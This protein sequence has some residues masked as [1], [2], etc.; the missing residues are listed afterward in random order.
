MEWEKA[1]ENNL[2]GYEVRANTA[3]K[4]RESG[5]QWNDLCFSSVYDSFTT[6]M[7]WAANG[8]NE[9]DL[10]GLVDS[11]IDLIKSHTGQVLPVLNMLA[12]IETL[13][14]IWRTQD[15]DICYEF[16][17][18]L[19]TQTLPASSNDAVPKDQAYASSLIVHVNTRLKQLNSAQ[20]ILADPAHG[21]G[22]TIAIMTSADTPMVGPV[23]CVIM[24]DKNHE[25]PLYLFKVR[26]AAKVEID[27]ACG[28]APSPAHFGESPWLGKVNDELLPKK[29]G[30]NATG[31]VILMGDFNVSAFNSDHKKAKEFFEPWQ[32]PLPEHIGHGT[33]FTRNNTFNEP[34]DKIL[35]RCGE[36]ICVELEG[37]LGRGPDCHAYSDHSY[38]T[39]TIKI[40]NTKQCERCDGSA[41]DGSGPQPQR[42][43]MDE[44]GQGQPSRL[45]RRNTRGPG[46]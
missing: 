9:Q 35:I 39:R 30:Q 42:E 8:S 25:R 41:A 22:E 23:K 15:L 31:P 32:P 2:Y 7:A 17:E 14:A 28:H 40:R 3:L 21:K 43:S 45:T 18:F 24:G 6:G 5:Q 20:F 37:D 16:A 12:N 1:R 27:I 36:S 34:Y 11:A 44:N 46:E 13:G 4:R 29:H 33:S 26:T 19:A 10:T 38:V